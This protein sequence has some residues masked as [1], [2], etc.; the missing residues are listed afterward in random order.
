MDQSSLFHESIEEALDEVVKALGGAKSVA[1]RMR[2]DLSPD[3]AARWLR[4]CLN[5]SRREHLTPGHVM[6][7]LRAGREAGVHAAMRFLA[8]EAGYSEPVPVSPEDEGADLM[9]RYI[10]AAQA[11]AKMSERIERLH[12]RVVA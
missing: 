5:D 12:V 9:R 7:L 8:R 3:A 2:P 10:E 4:D 6:W 1:A 11:L